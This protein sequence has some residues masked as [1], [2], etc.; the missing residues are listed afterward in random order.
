MAGEVVREDAFREGQC[1]GI[2]LTGRQLRAGLIL[3]A[4][5]GASVALLHLDD[6]RRHPVAVRIRVAW[7]T[8]ASVSRK[9]N[10]KRSNGLVVASQT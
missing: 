8:P 6:E 9:M 5:C 3:R 4:R 1:R 7:T 2:A 10:V